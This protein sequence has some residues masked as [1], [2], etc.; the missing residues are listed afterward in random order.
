[1][2]RNAGPFRSLSG[3]VLCDSFGPVGHDPG[4]TTRIPPALE[5]MSG[6]VRRTSQAGKARAREPQKGHPISL[7]LPFPRSQFLGIKKKGPALCAALMIL[8]ISP[9]DSGPGGPADRPHGSAF[10]CAGS[11]RSIDPSASDRFAIDKKTRSL[12]AEGR[13]ESA[14]FS[15]F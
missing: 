13:K 2:C 14:V 11:E 1:L 7:A 9:S 3:G 5:E 8:A 4:C 10:S 12:D 15:L 6:R